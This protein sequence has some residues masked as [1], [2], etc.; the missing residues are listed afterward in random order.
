MDFLIVASQITFASSTNPCM[1]CINCLV[2]G[3]NACTSSSSR[4]GSRSHQ[5]IHHSSCTVYM[6]IY[7][8]DIVVL[9]S[10]EELVEGMIQRLGKKFPTWNLGDLNLFLGILVTRDSGGLHM[11]QTQ[12]LLTCC[13]AVTWP[14][15]DWLQLQWLQI[16]S[17]TPTKSRSVSQRSSAVWSGPYSI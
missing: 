11:C 2:C 3:F 1:A 13:A 12:Y 7:V 8:D 6:F 14:T 5:R 17:F 10:N 4:L 9:G 15:C 16:S